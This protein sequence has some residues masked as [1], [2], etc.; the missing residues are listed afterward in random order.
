MTA[1]KSSIAAAFDVSYR[2]LTASQKS[3][4]RR[5]GLHVGTTIDTYAAAAIAGADVQHAQR[6]L[7][8]LQGEGLL[9]EVGYHRYAMHDL[10][11]RY[12]QYRAAA[13]PPADRAR[14]LDRLL[15]YY[16]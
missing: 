15:A 4:F 9:I 2:C 7:D 14:A 16:E 5:I 6:Y 3:F 13:D 12:A 11:R 8:A 1:E 10:V